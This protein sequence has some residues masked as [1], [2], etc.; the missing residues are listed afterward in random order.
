MQGSPGQS[1]R[2]IHVIACPADSDSMFRSQYQ[3]LINETNVAVCKEMAS[4][5]RPLPEWMKLWQGPLIYEDVDDEA[6]DLWV[7]QFQEVLKTKSLKGVELQVHPA[8]ARPVTGKPIINCPQAG[9]TA[10]KLQVP[11][12]TGNQGWYFFPL[13]LFQF[14]H[15]TYAPLLRQTW[16][17]E[18]FYWQINAPRILGQFSTFLEEFVK[19]VGNADCR[20]K[21]TLVS[22][23][24]FNDRPQA[25]DKL[26][27]VPMDLP[28]HQIYVAVK[29][30][31]TKWTLTYYDRARD[32][33]TGIRGFD[34]ALGRGYTFYYSAEQIQKITD[35]EILGYPVCVEGDWK[36]IQDLLKELKARPLG[37]SQDVIGLMRKVGTVEE[38]TLAPLQRAQ[39][40]N[41]INCMWGS[42]EAFLLDELG[43][44][45]FADVKLGFRC[46]LVLGCLA[47]L[48]EL[49]DDPSSSEYYQKYRNLMSS[50]VPVLM[51][52]QQRADMRRPGS[53][54]VYGH[55][56]DQ[57]MQAIR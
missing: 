14:S 31:D 46:H 44:E 25:E 54:Q 30:G 33:E 38:K 39:H 13:M 12:V 55:L 49:K 42:L 50:L 43:R 51:R 48:S 53:G 2:H 8:M 35:G 36:Q 26:S 21:I 29:K 40:Q 7:R 5:Q 10:Q 20:Q 1:G 23:A 11:D 22:S 34:N 37:K 32:S 15:Y 9:W 52:A 45:C 56:L 19:Q 16:I 28:G 17:D 6:R 3:E 4:R 47:K 41:T 57:L 24:L 27:L 18:T